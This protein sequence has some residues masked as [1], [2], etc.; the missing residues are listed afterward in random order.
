MVSWNSHHLAEE[1]ASD[2]SCLPRIVQFWNPFPRN[3]NHS[4]HLDS[5]ETNDSHVD[6]G[7]WLPIW[8]GEDLGHIDWRRG[9]VP[10]THYPEWGSLRILHMVKLCRIPYA[11]EAFW[12]RGITSSRNYKKASCLQK[13]QQD[14]YD[15]DDWESSQT[16]RG[17][18]CSSE[19][20]RHK[21]T[22]KLIFDHSPLMTNIESVYPVNVKI[23]KN[24]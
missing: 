2:I 5:Y 24:T 18:S 9:F 22:L 23:E 16:P 7:K 20:N 6:Q 3:F 8:W 19:W 10:F 14:Y 13:N 15:L 17:I 11:D 21:V 4:S 12:V 1:E